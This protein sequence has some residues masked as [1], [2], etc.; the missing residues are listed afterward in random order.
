MSRRV[1][2]DRFEEDARLRK[3]TGTPTSLITTFATAADS[4]PAGRGD[5]YLRGPSRAGFVTPV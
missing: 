3:A 4:V 1:R 5:A 2:L